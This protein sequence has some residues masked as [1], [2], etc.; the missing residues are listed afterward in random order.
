MLPSNLMAN[1]SD[2]RRL[3]CA[4]IEAYAGRRPAARKREDISLGENVL[5]DRTFTVSKVYVNRKI[6]CQ[7]NASN[8]PLGDNVNMKFPNFLR[9]WRDRIGMSQVALAEAAGIT[10]GYLSGLEQ[11]K[12]PYNQELL[13]KLG[14]AL[15]VTEADLIGTNPDVSKRPAQYIPI[16]GKA[17]GGANGEFIDAYPAGGHPE[18]DPF[19]EGSMA[20]DLDGDSMEPRFYHGEK[21]I[22]G[23]ESRDPTNYVGREVLARLTDGRLVVKTLGRNKV[24]GNWN[25][26]SYNPR[27]PIIEDVKVEW[28]RPFEGLRH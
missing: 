17:A 2:G 3:P 21:L 8:R 4:S 5:I 20:I 9:A 19:P 23:P 25:L 6:Y 26:I 13:Q 14:Q 28:V 18:V 22:F 11:G 7:C 12:K 27:H 15:G 1:S 24:T 10:A 16:M